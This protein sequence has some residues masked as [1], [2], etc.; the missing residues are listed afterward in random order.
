[1]TAQS[2][3]LKL[4]GSLYTDPASISS[5]G[6]WIAGSWNENLPGTHGFLRS[7]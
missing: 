4:P 5:A 2:G 3:R 1:M 6:G 7:P